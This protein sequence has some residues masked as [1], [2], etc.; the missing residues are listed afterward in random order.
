M[1]PAGPIAATD[2]RCAIATPALLVIG[3]VVT[4]HQQLLALRQQAM[5]S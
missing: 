5:I 1:R 2:C 3:K 4:L